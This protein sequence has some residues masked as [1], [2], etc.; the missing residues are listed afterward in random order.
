MR[1]PEKGQLK[2][3]DGQILDIYS[4]KKECFTLDNIAIGLAHNSR[5]H[6]QTTNMISVLWHSLKVHEECVRRGL[7]EW[8]CYQGLMHDAPEAFLQDIS[9]MLKGDV[10]YRDGPAPVRDPMMNS[11][12]VWSRGQLEDHYWNLLCEKYSIER[13]FAAEVKE[14]DAYMGMMEY[15]Y[16]YGEGPTHFDSIVAEVPAGMGVAVSD[17]FFQASIFKNLVT[18]YEKLK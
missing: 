13:E 10:Y 3:A 11:P 14:V 15:E 12:D 2:L 16:H 18:K 9:K 17:T 6:G 5:F 4:P 7:P 1:I 8:M